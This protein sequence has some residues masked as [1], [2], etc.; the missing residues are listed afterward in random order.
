VEITIEEAIKITGIEKEELLKTLEN[1]AIYSYNERKIRLCIEKKNGNVN[2]GTSSEIYNETP[3]LPR[4]S[5]KTVPRRHGTRIKEYSPNYFGWNDEFAVEYFYI[6]GHW[7]KHG[8][9]NDHD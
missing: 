5:K 8:Y 9:S 3:F 4:K 2:I 7:P 6:N 1:D